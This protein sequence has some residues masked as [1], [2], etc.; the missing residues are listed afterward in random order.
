MAAARILIIDD[1][2]SVAALYGRVLS[3]EGYEVR[4]TQDAEE[5]LK[6]ADVFQPD[7]VIVDFRMPMINGV[8][9]LYRLRERRHLGDVPVVMVTGQGAVGD[10]VLADLRLLGASVHYKPVGQQD[11]I[12]I[13]RGVLGR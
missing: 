13:A 8:G 4:V 7:L 2:A 6:A 11:L 5:G 1:D 3:Q 10:D 12:A 9:F